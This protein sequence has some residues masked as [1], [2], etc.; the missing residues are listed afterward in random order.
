V[1]GSF[2]QRH[3]K[4]GY[5]R[6][7][8]GHP[9]NTSTRPPTHRHWQPTG[10][11]AEGRAGDF[12][13]RQSFERKGGGIPRWDSDEKIWEARS[14]GGGGAVL[15]GERVEQVEERPEATIDGLRKRVLI[16]EDRGG[17]AAGEDSVREPH[18]T[19]REAPL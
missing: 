7:R 4:A 11:S 13:C 14:H 19:A 16:G 8:G 2:W 3:M 9:S 17:E 1:V 12:V 18:R 6:R 10:T 5:G 15:R